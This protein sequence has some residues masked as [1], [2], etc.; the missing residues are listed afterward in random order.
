MDEATHARLVLEMA[1]RLKK[2]MT[3]TVTKQAGYARSDKPS[4]PQP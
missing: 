2:N 4:K 3:D 1:R